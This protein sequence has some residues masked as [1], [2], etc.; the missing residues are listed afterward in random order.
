MTAQPRPEM[1]K[2][3]A[4]IVPPRLLQ[5]ARGRDTETQGVPMP[6][7]RIT[8]VC[9][10]CGTTF[11]VQPSRVHAGRGKFCSHGCAPNRR[12]VPLLDR[13]WAQVDRSSTDGCWPWTGTLLGPNGYGSIRVD[14]RVRHSNR[15]AWEIVAGPIPDGLHALHTCDFRACV[16]NDDEGVYVLRGVEHQRRGHLW[17]GT[18][19][20]NMAD[21]A[22]KGRAYRAFG[23]TNPNAHLTAAK[24]RSIRA[25]W[26]TGAV[27]K[28]E[29]GNMFGVSRPTISRIIHGIR[30][31]HVI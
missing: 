25:I 13:F 7:E 21:K 29:I 17:L 31:T 18:L 30:W 15:I 28:A 8:R 24:V 27:T 12:G 6:S 11:T 3:T 2:L 1:V 20:D 26:A 19:D 4:Q 22:D 14:G 16:R 23:E 9:P 5:T 10:S